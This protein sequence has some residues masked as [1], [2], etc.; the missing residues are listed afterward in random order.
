MNFLCYF[1]ER[2]LGEYTRNSASSLPDYTQLIALI[3]DIFQFL[4]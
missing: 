1:T 2:Y 4:A 3:V